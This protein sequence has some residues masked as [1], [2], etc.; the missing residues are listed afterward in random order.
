MLQAQAVDILCVKF[1][2]SDIERLLN[3]CLGGNPQSQV[4]I[5]LPQNSG[6][7]KDWL[8]GVEAL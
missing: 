4:N 2:T 5:L 1:G 8:R 3:V 6:Y 7:S